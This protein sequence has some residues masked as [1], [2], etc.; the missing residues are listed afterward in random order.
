MHERHVG[1]TTKRSRK[2]RDG[3]AVV[4]SDAAIYKKNDASPLNDYMDTYLI[5]N[6]KKIRSERISDQSMNKASSESSTVRLSR[7]AYH[8]PRVFLRHGN[9]IHIH[10]ILIIGL[11]LF[12]VHWIARS[13]LLF[14]VH[15]AAVT[16][17]LCSKSELR[18]RHR[19]AEQRTPYRFWRLTF[20]RPGATNGQR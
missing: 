19:A 13:R 20:R 18:R 2:R 4:H 12:I 16:L 10:S 7:R 11:L 8:C 14:I 9:V 6:V 5:Y 1:N 3:M 15:R 17:M